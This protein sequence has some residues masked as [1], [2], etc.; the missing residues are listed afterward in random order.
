MK[1]EIYNEEKKDD[2]LR[3]RLIKEGPDIVL[4]AVDEKGVILRA[5]RILIILSKGKITR[6]SY[7]NA[8]LGLPSNDAGQVIVI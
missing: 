5:G 4:A 6:C 3:L 1:I 2:V 7:V 8:G